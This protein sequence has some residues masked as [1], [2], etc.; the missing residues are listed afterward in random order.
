MPESDL[1]I[2][3]HR[4]WRCRAPLSWTSLG[5][6][7]HLMLPLSSLC[8]AAWNPSCSHPSHPWSWK[9]DYHLHVWRLLPPPG[10]QKWR[11]SKL[12]GTGLSWLLNLISIKTRGWQRKDMNSRHSTVTVEHRQ[13]HLLIA[14]EKILLSLGGV[15]VSWSG[16]KQ[17]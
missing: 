4:Q 3:C 2:S 11:T 15:K 8:A 13:P 6:E 16:F 1:A 9:G 7:T 5:V 17:R 12:C 10:R 14:P